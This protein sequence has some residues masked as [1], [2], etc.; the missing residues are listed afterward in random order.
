MCVSWN[1]RPRRPG[2]H[3]IQG[4]GSLDFMKSELPEALIL[5]NSTNRTAWWCDV[6][7]LWYPWIVVSDCGIRK[8]WC[9]SVEPAQCKRDSFATI[10]KSSESRLASLQDYQLGCEVR[11]GRSMETSLKG[12]G[13]ACTCMKYQ[14][15]TNM[16]MQT[17]HPFML[18]KEVHHVYN[19]M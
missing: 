8:L 12:L 19:V 6:R 18:S 15:D 7:E 2:F 1:P 16:H 11:S 9:M 13:Y 4:P 14:T 10:S 5:R 3:E 17:M